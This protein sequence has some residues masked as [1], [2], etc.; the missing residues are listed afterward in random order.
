[1]LIEIYIA[2]IGLAATFTV[3]T[4]YFRDNLFY[5]WFSPFTWLGLALS[6]SQ[7][8][9]QKC[10]YATDYINTTIS[11]ITN[12][13]NV[14]NCVTHT[15]EQVPLI[16]LFMGIGIFMFLWAIVTTLRELPKLLR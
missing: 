5:A 2:L 16:Y 13:T 3:L 14:W 15:V 6:S 4:F 11:N 8:Q 7:V 10:S 12:H 9:Y 1:M